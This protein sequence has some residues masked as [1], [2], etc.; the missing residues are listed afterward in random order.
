MITPQPGYVVDPTNPNA[1][2]KAPVKTDPVVATPPVVTDPEAEKTRIANQGKPGYDV[3]GNPV[4]PQSPTMKSIYSGL[5]SD[6]A[7]NDAYKT[8][9]QNAKTDSEQTIDEDQIR[10]DTLKSFQ[11]EIDAQ[12]SIFADKLAR[13]KVT[14]ANRIGS[15]T[16]I[17]ARRGTLGSD[18]GEANIDNIN[19]GNEEVYSGIENERGAAV[20]KILTQAR[21]DAD[22]QIADKTAAKS[23]G[24][25]NYVKYLQD[26]ATRKTTNATTA[27]QLLL[28]NGTK[29][30]D[31]KPEDLT[32]LTQSYGISSN[33]LKTAYSPLL[34]AAQKAKKEQD[35]KDLKALDDH[36]TTLSTIDKNKATT[37]LAEKQFNEDVRQFGMSYALD[38]KKLAL[39][40]LK[41]DITNPK[42]P[43]NIA[44][45]QGD[46]TGTINLIN[47]L[48]NNPH[49]SRISGFFDGKLG[50]GSLYPGSDT[51]LAK[52]QYDQ[53]KG[54][55]SLENRGKLKGQGA[56]SDFEGKMLE[57]SASALSRNLGDDE[58]KR[59]LIQV[60]GAISTSHGLPAKVLITDPKD[61]TSQELDSNSAGI[62]A[63]VKDGMLVEYK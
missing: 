5:G 36:N 28:N 3:Y 26:G 44:K 6:T 55:L 12:N 62:A 60:K 53:I 8:Q 15:G 30:E 14:G 56:V 59:Q 27:A 58:F 51:N 33:D 63:A 39:E 45:A 2:I 1:V 21:T 13:A 34:V 29:I 23:A 52:N 19:S 7:L 17:N 48:L 35:A 41:V 57:S 46:A 50:L 42:S 22:K 16:A 40:Q 38:Q 11:A 37:A 10:S 61:G 9:T 31:L 25:D 43:E 20:S 54:L 47:T 24:L 32:A 18:F 4:L 49:L